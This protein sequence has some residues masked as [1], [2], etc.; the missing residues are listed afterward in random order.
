[1]V[2]DYI[3]MFAIFGI[4]YFALKIGKNF[5]RYI[6]YYSLSLAQQNLLNCDTD[7]NY[8]NSSNFDSSVVFGKYYTLYLA[9]D[10]AISQ[11]I[12]DMYVSKAEEHNLH[13]ENYLTSINRI[14]NKSDD[15]V[16][17]D[18][19]LIEA[20]FDSGFDLIC[21][22]EFVS[23][24]GSLT[25]IDHLVKCCMKYNNNYVGYYLYSRSSTATKTPLRL[26][27]N[28]GII[29]SGYR[30]NIKVAF[31]NYSQ[32]I[33]EFKLDSGNRY[34]QFCPPN[35]EYPMKVVI[36]DDVSNLGKTARDDGGFGS[37]G[38]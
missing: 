26:A 22:E 33:R 25:L 16:D 19:D 35:L 12:K 6:R 28:V 38:K 23:K 9:F 11:T 14:S 24:S 36:V 30:G 1:M 4:S 8:S 2:L 3:N 32:N 27:N 5:V 34:V 7:S 21:P 13:I 20:C 18:C 29:D 37:T 10:P 15:E 31:D 17:S